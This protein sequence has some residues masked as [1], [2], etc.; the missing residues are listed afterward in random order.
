MAFVTF[1]G[2]LLYK[3][4]ITDE[5]MRKMMSL[6]N[7]MTNVHTMYT[8]NTNEECRMRKNINTFYEFS[9]SLEF[10][11]NWLKSKTLL[12]NVSTVIF[13]FRG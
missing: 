5:C 13:I 2:P 3:G 9:V 10:T 4:K 7:N 8:K 6:Y 11:V 12:K 1:R